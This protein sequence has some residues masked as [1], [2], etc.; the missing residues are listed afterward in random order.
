MTL[1]SVVLVSPVTGAGEQHHRSGLSC[2]SVV[3]DA[4]RNICPCLLQVLDE[5][6]GVELVF[7]L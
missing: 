3:L 2:G 4:L 7:Q 1:R 5:C 6:T